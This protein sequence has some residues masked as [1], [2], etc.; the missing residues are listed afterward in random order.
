MSRTTNS[1]VKLAQGSQP[2]SST[3]L[4]AALDAIDIPAAERAVEDL[5]KRRQALLI[6]GPDSAL[7]AI[8]SE[9]RT[10]EREIDR[11]EAVRLLL[12]KRLEAAEQD[13]LVAALEA[14][15]LT[16]KKAQ[17]AMMEAYLL[18]DGAAKVII[19]QRAIIAAK[20]SELTSANEYAR[21]HDRKDLVVRDPLAILVEHLGLTTVDKLPQIEGWWLNGYVPMPAHG[22][23]FAHF[24]ELLLTR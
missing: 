11:L 23:A 5:Q 3:E 19:E 15:A 17:T 2:T 7:E 13:E 8:E 4:R 18:L 20:R 22:A 9:I 21:K 16:A 6:A 10:A 1:L 24:R 12:E 14:S